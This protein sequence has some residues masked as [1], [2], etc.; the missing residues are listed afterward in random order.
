MNFYWNVINVV[1]RFQKDEII[2]YLDCRW[3]TTETLMQNSYASSPEYDMD[4]FEESLTVFLNKYIT[5]IYLIV[6]N[7]NRTIMIEEQQQTNI[8]WIFYVNDK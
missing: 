6:Q 7:V 4:V 1:F 5:D 3:V 8:F 2:A